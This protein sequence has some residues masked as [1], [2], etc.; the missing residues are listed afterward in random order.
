MDIKFQRKGM[1]VVE[2]TSLL[3]CLPL[4][5]MVVSSCGMEEE[6]AYITNN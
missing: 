1:Q 4:H 3:W 2:S 6:V 5:A